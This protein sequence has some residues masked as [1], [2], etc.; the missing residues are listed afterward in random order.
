MQPGLAEQ[1]IE[2]C[3]GAELRLRVFIAKLHLDAERDVDGGISRVEACG[4]AERLDCIL[5]VRP[6]GHSVDN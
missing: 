3:G 5:F 6:L 4:A 2:V 1:G